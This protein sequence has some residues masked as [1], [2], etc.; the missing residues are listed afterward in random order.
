[1]EHLKTIETALALTTAVQAA[2]DEAASLKEELESMH[3]WADE[4]ETDHAKKV[5]ALKDL[6][7]LQKSMMALQECSKFNARS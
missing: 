2:Q 1:M 6:V 4:T 7:Q 5:E 3:K